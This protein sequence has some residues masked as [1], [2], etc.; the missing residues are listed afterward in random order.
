[1]NESKCKQTGRCDTTARITARWLA[2]TQCQL[3]PRKEESQEERGR[4]AG[5]TGLRADLMSRAVCGSRSPLPLRAQLP[6]TPLCL[7]PLPSHNDSY[8][9]ISDNSGPSF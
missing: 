6:N 7:N 2:E 4:A 9:Y 8:T 3:T 5:E 1:M